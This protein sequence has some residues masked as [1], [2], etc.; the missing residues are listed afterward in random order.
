MHLT[1]I[2]AGQ[3]RTPDPHRLNRR[4]EQLS[5]LEKHT[6]PDFLTQKIEQL[7]DG[8]EIIPSHPECIRDIKQILRML[9]VAIVRLEKRFAK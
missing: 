2:G 8:G 9:N 5:N 4:W 1:A 3:M 7:Y 6:D